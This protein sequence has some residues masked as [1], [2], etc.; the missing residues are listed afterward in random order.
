MWGFSFSKVRK[1]MTEKNKDY[2]FLGTGL[3]KGEK[4]WANNQFKSYRERYHIENFSDLEILSELVFRETLQQR[5]KKKIEKFTSK[6][7]GKDNNTVIPQHLL[8]F[9][10]ENLERILTL[11]EKLGLFEDKTTDPF[12][13]IQTLKKK[14]KKWLSE[15]QGSRSFPCPHC[16]KM[17]MLKIRTDKWESK[18]HPFFKDR[19]LANKHLWE[20]YKEG[21]IT[22]E[23]VA[24]VLGTSDRYINWLEERIYNKDSENPSE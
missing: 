20:M 1:N 7:K 16:S 22:K 3:T 13:H 5:T 14:F 24:K 9:L 2:K 23:D 4:R 11:K 10:D 19:I 6:G 18:K 8:S 12:Q 15:N 21:K 17:I